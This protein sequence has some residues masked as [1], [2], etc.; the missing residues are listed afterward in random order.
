ML[1]KLDQSRVSAGFQFR[2]DMDYFLSSRMDSQVY[3]LHCG[4]VMQ[5]HRGAP[6]SVDSRLAETG[7][8]ERNGRDGLEAEGKQGDRRLVGRSAR[9]APGCSP[10]AHPT[11][12]AAPR[13]ASGTTRCGGALLGHALIC[14]R[15]SRSI[16]FKL[17]LCP[18]VISFANPPHLGAR[19]RLLCSWA[20]DP[21]LLAPPAL[22]RSR[23]EEW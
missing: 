7:G 4:L 8:P 18:G 10:C 13:G 9:S 14:M 17:S 3:N 6:I 23:L 1:G 11:S 12:R 16:L 21:G 20:S 2:I 22:R 15:V 19:G 5:R